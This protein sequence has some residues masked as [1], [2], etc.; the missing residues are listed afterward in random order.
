M[1]KK[2]LTSQ[3]LALRRRYS[4]CNSTESDKNIITDSNGTEAQLV[5]D[6]NSWRSQ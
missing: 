3:E 2:N 5:Y 6:A 4:T 1:W